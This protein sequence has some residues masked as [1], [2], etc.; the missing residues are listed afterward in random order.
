MATDSTR[1]RLLAAAEKILVEQGVNALSVRRV[2]DGA[3]QNPALVTYHFKSLFNLL[4]E[5]CSINL[6][7]ML[8]AWTGI[9]PGR[10]LTADEVLRQWLAPMLRPAAFTPNGRAL[11][12]L[13]GLAAHGEPALRER[14]LR[15]MEEFSLRLRGAL[16]PSLPHL[17][18]DE[19][20]ARVRFI[21]GAALGPPPRTNTAPLAGSVRLDDMHF[22]LPFAR[23]ALSLPPAE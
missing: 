2:G 13:D 9:G 12:V 15:S 5:L 6:E 20:R 23:A 1:T 21:S 4:D 22:L 3:G 19:I 18:D 10:G 7:P 8:E 14:V 11:A 17:T 16:A